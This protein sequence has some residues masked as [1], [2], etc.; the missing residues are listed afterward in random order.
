[1]PHSVCRTTVPAAI[2]SQLLYAAPS[3]LVRISREI[4]KDAN[5]VFLNPFLQL[6]PQGPSASAPGSAVSGGYGG[7][8]PLPQGH[9]L[10]TPGPAGFDASADVNTAGGG[11]APDLTVTAAG[12]VMRFDP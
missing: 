2:E 12:E 11:T 5:R 7:S 4:D 9:T 1:M 3:H 8:T 10:S 6:P